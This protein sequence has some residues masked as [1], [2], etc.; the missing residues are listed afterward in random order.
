MKSWKP[1][2]NFDNDNFD[3]DGPFEDTI[4]CMQ[5]IKAKGGYILSCDTSIPNLSGAVGSAEEGKPRTLMLLNYHAD[6]RWGEVEPGGSCAKENR[7]FE[8]VLEFRQEKEGEW[9]PVMDN[10]I[11]YINEYE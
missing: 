8:D 6:S 7:F 10:V 3:G 1:F 4:A 2:Y 11:K 5:A 9:E